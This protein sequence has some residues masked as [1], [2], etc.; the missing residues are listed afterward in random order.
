[1][2]WFFRCALLLLW[3]HDAKDDTDA[4]C[5]E[6][7]SSDNVLI[8]GLRLPDVFI[9]FISIHVF[10][11]IIFLLSFLSFPG[12]TINSYWFWIQITPKPRCWISG[13]ADGYCVKLRLYLYKEKAKNVRICNKVLPGAQM[14]MMHSMIYGWWRFASVQLLK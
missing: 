1:M 9:A 8:R 11:F 7:V 6:G 14:V 13:I 10:Y 5:L 2:G 3:E 4:L 12:K